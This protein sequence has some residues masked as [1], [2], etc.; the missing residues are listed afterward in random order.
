MAVS[1]SLLGADP[2]QTEAVAKTPPTTKLHNLLCSL[3]FIVNL[4]HTPRVRGI[5]QERALRHGGVKPVVWLLRS[6][7]HIV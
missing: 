4:Q 3:L 2:A 1:L 5:C 6:I 7:S